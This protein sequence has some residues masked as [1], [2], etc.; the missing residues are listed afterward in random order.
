[1]V[2][3]NFFYAAIEYKELADDAAGCA[4]PCSTALSEEKGRTKYCLLEE[5]SKQ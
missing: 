1:M 4:C 2:Q 5:L 3:E